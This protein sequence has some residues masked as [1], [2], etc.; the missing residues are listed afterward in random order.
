M[1]SHTTI[2]SDKK[3]LNQYLAIPEYRNIGAQQFFDEIVNEQKPV[4]LR[5]FAS[6]WPMVDEAKKGAS[7]FIEYVGQFYNG[8]KAKIS[9]APPEAN[10]RFTYN[11]DLDGLTFV[12][13]DERFDLFAKRLLQLRH[14]DNPPALSLQSAPVETILPGL[15]EANSSAFFEQVKPRL[16][17]GNQGVV[18][19]HFDGTD[20]LACVVAGRRKFTLFAPQQTGDLYPGPLE[21]TPAGVPVSL[22]NLLDPDLTRFPRFANALDNAY[23]A[24]LDPGDAIFIPMLWWHHVEALENVNALMNYWWNGSFASNAVSPN[25]LDSMKMTI[26]AMRDFTPAQRNAWRNLFDHYLFRQ[27]LDPTA[28]IPKHQHHILGNL[29]PEY[30]REIKDYFINKLK[31]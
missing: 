31:T 21:F 5:D 15:L 16:W 23:Q 13:G 26:L 14:E 22:V 19:T 28:H 12:S 8:A 6:H 17:V 10:K 27:N 2:N 1:D 20:N 25:F 29:S 3:Q 4:V 30:I 7:S 18:D 9:I 11:Q 24:D